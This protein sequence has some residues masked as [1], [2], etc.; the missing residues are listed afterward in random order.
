MT[1]PDMLAILWLVWLIPLFL[2]L[3]WFL[4]FR[5][6]EA[7]LGIYICIGPGCEFGANAT[8]EEFYWCPFGMLSVECRVL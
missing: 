3:S 1:M 4:I 7:K 2:W 8:T 5:S 6:S